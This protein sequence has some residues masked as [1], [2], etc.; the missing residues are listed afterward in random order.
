MATIGNDPNGHKRILFVAPDGKRKTIRL[1]KVTT[2]QATA[3]KAKVEA[4][5]GQTITGVVDDEVSRWLAGLDAEIYG[6]LA[7]EGLAQPRDS[8]RLD[9]FLDGY[10][11]RR[12]DVKPLTRRNLQA[13]RNKLVRF[14][15]ADKCLRDITAGDA[16][17]WKTWLKSQ[18]ASGTTG[19]AIKFGKQYFRAALRGRLIAAN[20]FDEV[21][22]P[23]QANESR[24][25]FV[26]RQDARKVLD[27]C[28]DAEWRLIFALSRYGGVRC[29]S[30][31][32]AL[33]WQDVDWARD[34]M[35]VSSPKTEGHDGHEGRW[36][37]LFP[38]LRPYLQAAFEEAEEGAIYVIN[39][40]RDPNKNFRTRLLR[41]FKRAGLKPW[42]K[43]FHNLR[44]SRQ[45]ELAAEYPIHVVC[46]WIGNSALIAA[47][48][49][50]QVTEEHYKQAAQ[51]PAQSAAGRACQQ[52]TGNPA[53]NRNVREIKGLHTMSIPVNTY[54][55]AR[56]ESNPQPADPKSAALSS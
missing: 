22:A 47:R 14:F 12:T 30:E 13:A 20:P 10:I 19:R 56:R 42:P 52:E 35:W 26:N 45:T 54:D 29:P 48:H 37:P 46:A 6:R 7:A 2:K 55:Y 3:F 32:L 40:Y 16:D 17:A 15:G 41:I 25:Y 36:V 18:Y 38:E 23:A 50:L 1:G 39:T 28:P 8:A 27:A 43:L 49:Y 33:R 51:I 21:S 5:I 53:Q 44:A 11:A 4:L 9:E 31:T 34:R 24:K